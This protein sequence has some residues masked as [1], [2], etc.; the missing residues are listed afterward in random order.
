MSPA[1]RPYWS[2]FSLAGILVS[3]F[4]L[5]SYF[6]SLQKSPVFDEPPHI[7]SGLSYIETGAFHFNLQHPPLL[8]EMSALSLSL[9]GI[10]WPKTP[11]AQKLI[12]GGPESTNIDW[13]MG[14]AI[15]ANDGPDRVMFWARLPFILLAALLGVTIYAWGRE[16]V[17]PAAALGALFL[18]A[19]DPTILAHSYLVTTDAGL[20]A[21]TVLFFWA[22]WRYVRHPGRRRVAM[23]GLAMG[24]VLAAKFSGLFWLPVAAVLLAA[25][26]RWPYA[27]VADA[28]KAEEPAQRGAR[29]GPNSPCPCGSGKKY[30]KCHGAGGAKLD[31]HVE[32]SLQRRKLLACAGA[33][34]AMCVIA[35][36]VVEALYFF[37]SDPFLYITGLKQVNADHRAAYQLYLHGELA[38]RFYSYF[39][40]AYLLKEPLA[41]IL[42][43]AAGVWVLLRS[44]STP[45]PTKLFLLLPPAVFLVAMTIFADDMGV[46]YIIP[47]MPF[48]YLLGGM[49]LAALFG[50]RFVWGRYVAVA[51]CLWVAIA[52]AGIYPDHL[53]Y[54]N[55][56]ACLLEK[57]GQISWDGGSRCGPLWL[58]DSN[59]DWGQ[60]VKQ[61][62]SWM[63]RHGKGRTLRLAYFG[64]FPPEGYGLRFEKVETASL[65]AGPSPGLY[66]VSAHLVAH[67]PAAGELAAPGAG[68]WMRRVAP[69][70]IVGHAFYIYDLR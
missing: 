60:G 33:F 67:L 12:H 23:C 3:A 52:A 41:T 37:P 69:V 18:Y 32:R 68:S 7:A 55:E 64:S 13:P 5:Q 29:P 51:L 50:R 42:L 34:L 2:H 14:N 63:D 28:D 15:I 36:V 57:P 35:V 43:A 4:L 31:Q 53:S 56:T 17:G 9:A 26:L 66:A 40:V 19:F 61:L 1:H 24:A 38:K 20:A 39:V 65:M 46:R 6:S 54:F 25:S 59:I 47:A 70:A 58:D 30:K 27:P 11:L 21:F 45:I 44:K 48:G 62:R 8:K 22:L 16:V 10:H 49:G